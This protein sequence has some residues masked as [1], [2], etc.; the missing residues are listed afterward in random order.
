[1]PYVPGTSWLGMLRGCLVGV[2]Q[3]V[4]EALRGHLVILDFQG[5][6]CFPDIID[7]VRWIRDHQVG[8]L[9][10]E[11]LSKVVW[12]FAVTAE[13]AVCS[14][15]EQVT[16]LDVG[17]DVLRDF[18]SVILRFFFIW[19]LEHISKVEAPGFKRWGVVIG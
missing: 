12:V 14:Y 11:K 10:C 18:K 8:L 13:Q 1:M 5:I 7:I 2:N 17:G 15:F 16:G 4:Q 19:Y 6:G 9:T 3:K